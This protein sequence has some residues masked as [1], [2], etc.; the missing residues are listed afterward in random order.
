VTPTT[1]S[2]RRTNAAAGG[3]ALLIVAACQLPCLGFGFLDWDDDL[4]VTR[5]LSVLTP[6]AVSLQDHLLTPALGY[7]IPITIAS[8]TLEA[9]SLGLEPWHFHL[10]NALLHLLNSGFVFALCRRLGVSYIGA[11]C[12]ALLFGLH[13]VVA[14]PVTW[15]SGRKDLLALGFGASALWL[16]LDARTRLHRFVAVSCYALGLLC[17]P[18]L[19]PLCIVIAVPWLDTQDTNAR[20]LDIRQRARVLIPYFAVLAPVA[21]VGLNGQKR[22]GALVDPASSGVGHARLIWY[23]LGHH[24]RLLSGL[25]QPT[26][27]YLP[28]PWPPSFSPGVDLLPLAAAATALLSLCV[29][30]GPLRRAALFGW[31][32][33]AL[34]Y[35]PS[36]N[37]IP[38]A[39]NLADSYVYLALVGVAIAVGAVADALVALTPRLTFMLR[40]ALPALFVALCLPAFARSQGRFRDDRSLWAQALLRYPSNPRVCR[41]WANG[42]AKVSGPGA[43]LSATDQCRERFGDDLFARNRA[44]LLTRLGRFD[45]VRE[46]LERAER[47]HPQHAPAGEAL[48]AR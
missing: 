17:K 42:V 22:V 5:N 3:V 40:W 26:V 21:L 28:T 45:E 31:T 23:S 35:A 2:A 46:W 24:L 30:T 14:E 7:P 20:P 34:M 16:A 27:K 32:W 18:S 38:L 39:R 1:A 12:A 36:S 19:A 10:I 25:E 6:A 8:Y 15:V 9:H 48:D 43:G 4:H 29:L 37:L 33:A 41:Q 47:L 13:P 44:V 11:S